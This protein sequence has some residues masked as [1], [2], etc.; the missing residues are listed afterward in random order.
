MSMDDHRVVVGN[1]RSACDAVDNCRG[2]RNVKAGSDPGLTPT[3]PNNLP[4]LAPL[5]PWAG[6]AV[7]GTWTCEGSY[8]SEDPPRRF[9]RISLQGWGLVEVLVE[10][11]TAQLR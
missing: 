8:G 11:F 4:W 7:R 2:T 6:E 1:K 9:T 5:G 10:P 3:C